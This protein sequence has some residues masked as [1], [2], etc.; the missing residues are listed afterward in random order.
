MQVDFRGSSNWLGCYSCCRF[1][2]LDGRFS[3]TEA[4]YEKL[5][6]LYK[7]PDEFVSERESG[8][9]HSY[10]RRQ[11][12]GGLES[13]SISRIYSCPST[14]PLSSSQGLDLT[15]LPMSWRGEQVVGR[16]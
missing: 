10:G 8:V 9:T 14:Y 2:P 13:E 3:G 11:G 4:R 1:A 6:E 15:I 5:I 12:F 7:I 16:D